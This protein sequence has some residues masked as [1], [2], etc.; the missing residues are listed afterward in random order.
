MNNQ[1]SAFDEIDKFVGL[2]FKLRLVD[3]HLVRDL[4]HLDHVGFHLSF[5]V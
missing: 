5:R 4:M 2:V 1:T 3:Q